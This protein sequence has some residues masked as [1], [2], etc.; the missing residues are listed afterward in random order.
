MPTHSDNPNYLDSGD[1]PIWLAKLGDFI[2]P[3]PNFRWRRESLAQ[4]DENHMRTGYG[5]NAAE[6]CRLASWELGSRCYDSV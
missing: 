3:L 5:F 4:H 6:E 2:V 1:E